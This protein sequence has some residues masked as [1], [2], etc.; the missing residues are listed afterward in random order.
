MEPKA[1]IIMAARNNEQ[2]GKEACGYQNK[3]MKKRKKPESN[4][5]SAENDISAKRLIAAHID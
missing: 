2:G 3:C 5:K 1:K 4:G